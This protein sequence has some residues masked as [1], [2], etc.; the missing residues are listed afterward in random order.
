MP[1]RHYI[2]AIVAFWLA[3]TAWLFQ[4]D[5]WPLFRPGEPPG[6]TIELADEASELRVRWTLYKGDEIRGSA[7]SA[8]VYREKEDQFDFVCTYKERLDPT[9]FGDKTIAG[10]TAPEERADSVYT[11]SRTGELVSISKNFTGDLT[12]MLEALHLGEVPGLKELLTLLKDYRLKAH[13]GGPV[14][15]GHLHPRREFRFTRDPEKRSA[16]APVIEEGLR[17][18]NQFMDQVLPTQLS[19]VPMSPRG[20]VFDPMHPLNRITGL[21]AGQ[22]WRMPYLYSLLEERDPTVRFLFAEV[23]TE[24]E[25]L[26]RGRASPDEC[27]AIRYA[28]STG[29]DIGARVWVRKNDGIVLQQEFTTRGHTFLLKRD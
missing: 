3:C 20:L 2:V 1:A 12:P 5:I 7:I 18:L 14:R 29:D 19:A 9:C 24:P 13:L 17:Q 27:L 8:V 22:H 23:L 28:G 21:R 11:V 4:R 15:D 26:P 6:F 16:G 10:S 25:Y